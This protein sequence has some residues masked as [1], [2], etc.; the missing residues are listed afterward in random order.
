VIVG[1]LHQDVGHLGIFVSGKVAKKEYTQLVSV[2]NE[3]EILPPGLYGMQI[4]EIE[5]DADGEKQY[6][7]TFQERRLEDI[8]ARGNRFGREDEKPFEAVAALSDFNQRAYELFAQP[9]VRAMSN[10]TSAKLL[11]TFHPLRVQNWALSSFNPFM[12]WLKPAAE[13]VKAH[14][15]PLEASDPW[16][17]LENAGSELVSA[18]L[19]LHGNM[20]DARTEASFFSIYANMYSFYMADKQPAQLEPMAASDMRALPFVQEALGSI[21]EGGYVE[22]FARL[23]SL[24]AAHQDDLLPLAQLV[25]RKELA[26]SY[27][28]YLP[29]VPRDQWRRIRGEQEIIARYAPEQ[30]IATLPALLRE[31]GDRE[32]LLALVDK[33][34]ADPRV[35][36]HPTDAQLA[37]VERLRDLLDDSAHPPVFAALPPAPAGPRL[38]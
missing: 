8:V 31:R 18:S 7:V 15:Q 36:E 5:S 34:M 11:R 9:L 21:A 3:V 19:D 33:L 2:L 23:A 28:E 14:R 37:M 16:R 17:R 26:P 22:A 38:H 12:A 29:D 25:K 10:D 4:T 27:A 24:R 6:E 30:A 32:R 35:Q 13:A 20:R 1:L